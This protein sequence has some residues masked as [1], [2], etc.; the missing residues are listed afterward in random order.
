VSVRAGVVG[1][2]WLPAT[3]RAMAHA[4]QQGTSREAEQTAQQ[5]ERLPYSRS[6]F[7][8]VGHTVGQLMTAN[9]S[10][11]EEQLIQQYQ[12][13]PEAYSI[14][15]GLDRVSIPMEEPLARPVG[16]PKADAPKH[17]GG[18]QLPDGLLRHA[19]A[20][21]QRGAGPAHPSLWPDAQGRRGIDR[22]GPRA[23][24]GLNPLLLCA[25]TILC[26]GLSRPLDKF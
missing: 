14:S 15:V 20:Q 23:P 17:P 3:A 25:L 7:E 21:R 8:D 9:H 26:S 2:G 22:G 12:V 5:W 11:I 18:P 10:R 6:S 19:D 16:R 13:P 1:A 24:N 4:L